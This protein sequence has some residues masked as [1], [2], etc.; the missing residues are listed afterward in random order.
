LLGA[1]LQLRFTQSCVNILVQ[2]LVAA[3]HSRASY[4]ENPFIDQFHFNI[5]LNTWLANAVSI[6]AIIVLPTVRVHLN[7]T[8]DLLGCLEAN[9]ARSKLCCGSIPRRDIAINVI[10]NLR[11]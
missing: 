10:Y 6:T 8:E 1:I 7:I 3:S 4:I 5:A 2:K 11:L 9:R